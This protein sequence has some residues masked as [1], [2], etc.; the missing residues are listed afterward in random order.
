MI[1]VYEKTICTVYYVRIHNYRA[2]YVHGISLHNVLIANVA[3]YIRHAAPA[4]VDD[5]Q[6]ATA[7]PLHAPF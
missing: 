2:P 6:I 4:Y 5:T 3:S 7:S 1:K